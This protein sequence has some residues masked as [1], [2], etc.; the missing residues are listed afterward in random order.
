[1]TEP[2]QEAACQSCRTGTPFAPPQSTFAMGN[3]FVFHFEQNY[4][5]SQAEAMQLG[6]GAFDNPAEDAEAVLC[7]SAKAACDLAN[8]KRQR[9]KGGTYADRF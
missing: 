2:C 1:M 5:E 3:R 9:R 7:G 8:D 4:G 6:Q